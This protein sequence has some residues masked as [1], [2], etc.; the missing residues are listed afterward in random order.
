[1]TRKKQLIVDLAAHQEKMRRL[2]PDSEMSPT[3]NAELIRLIREQ[4]AVSLTEGEML[5]I[6]HKVKR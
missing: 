5:R 6:I 3:D 1:M 4:R 2:D